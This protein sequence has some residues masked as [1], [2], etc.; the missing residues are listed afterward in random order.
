MILNGHHR[1]AAALRTDIKRIPVNIINITHEVD[2]ENMLRLSDHDKRVSL[3]L[4]EVILGFTDE[5]EL[6]RLCDEYGITINGEF[7]SPS[8]VDAS[9]TDASA[10]DASATD[11]E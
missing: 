11:A 2:I 4:D 1:W 8:L 7:Q 9:V 3:D 10:S 6:E 5:D